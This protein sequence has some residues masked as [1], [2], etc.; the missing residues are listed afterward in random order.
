MNKKIIF[1]PT[2]IEL[3]YYKSHLKKNRRKRYNISE[4]GISHIAFSVNDLKKT[5]KKF[6]KKK[7]KFIC[8]PRLSADRKVLISFC[9]APEGTLIELA[10]EL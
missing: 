5:Y 8:P 4:I 1:L 10:Q 2:M 9:R 7:I 3:L 6:S